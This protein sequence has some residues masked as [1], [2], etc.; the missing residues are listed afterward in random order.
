MF[1]RYGTACRTEGVAAL[2]QQL[3]RRDSPVP[4][5]V[6]FLRPAA[7]VIAARLLSCARSAAKGGSA[8]WQ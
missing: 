5:A 4:A 2:S 1:C 3:P 7:G 8:G 6:Q